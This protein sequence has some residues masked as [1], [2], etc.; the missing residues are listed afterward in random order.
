MDGSGL[1]KEKAAPQSA[2]P[3]RPVLGAI[4]TSVFGRAG[5]GWK[6][7]F[8][9]SCAALR[10]EPAW[11]QP[12]THHPSSIILHPFLPSCPPWWTSVKTIRYPITITPSRG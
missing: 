4:G 12:V 3:G 7:S 1:C 10:V 2:A 8:D 6:A 9:R 11:S 5:G